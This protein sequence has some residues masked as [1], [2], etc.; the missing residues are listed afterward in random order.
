MFAVAAV[1]L[2]KTPLKICLRQEVQN[3]FGTWRHVANST[4]A[5][6][7]SNPLRECPA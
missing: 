1:S 5:D 4:N 6:D 2:T 7:K 3:L